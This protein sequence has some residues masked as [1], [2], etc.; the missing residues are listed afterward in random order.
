MPATQTANRNEAASIAE[1][2]KKEAEAFQPHTFPLESEPSNGKQAISL[3]TY[4]SAVLQI[5]E[6]I[7]AYGIVLDLD[8]VTLGDLRDIRDRL[9]SDDCKWHD[10]TA[11]S[12]PSSS[13][14]PESLH[15]RHFGKCLYDLTGSG[16]S[17]AQMRKATGKYA[18][19]LGKRSK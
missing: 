17:K 10:C 3:L 18:T 7:D 11:V 16:M 6:L 12:I 13:A 5:G 15:N 1:A 2:A 8:N 9:E 14:I 19:E 4:A